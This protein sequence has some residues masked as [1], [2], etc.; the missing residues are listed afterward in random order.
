MSECNRIREE[1]F[2]FLGEVVKEWREERLDLEKVRG[3]YRRFQ[4]ER[5]G[6]RVFRSV[7]AG[8]TEKKQLSSKEN[9]KI[10]K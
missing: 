3:E 10:A 8:N 9:K 1:N 5:H 7:V 4:L 2:V 6:E